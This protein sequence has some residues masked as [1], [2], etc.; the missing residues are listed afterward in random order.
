MNAVLHFLTTSL[1]NVWSLFPMLDHREV[2][3][4]FSAGRGKSVPAG[5]PLSVPKGQLSPCPVSAGADFS[6]VLM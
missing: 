1:C 6:R 5:G 2:K 4:R 3:P